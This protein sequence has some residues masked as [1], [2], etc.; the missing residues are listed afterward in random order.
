MQVHKEKASLTHEVVTLWYRAPEV[1]RRPARAASDPALARHLRS[2][3]PRSPAPLCALALAPVRRTCSPPRQ[4][5]LGSE[6]YSSPLDAWSMG[7]VLAELATGIPLLP[8]DSE[9][10]QLVKTFK[11]FGTPTDATWPGVSALP[12]FAPTS[13]SFQPTSLEEKLPQLAVPPA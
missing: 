13:P 10:G 11:L 4:V 1:P 8:G 3:S 12:N 9:I 7:A 6:H 2:P 5:L